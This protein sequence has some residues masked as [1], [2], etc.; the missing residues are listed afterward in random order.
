MATY[1]NMRR[2]QARQQIMLTPRAGS[3]SINEETLSNSC[4]GTIYEGSWS[5]LSPTSNKKPLL[6]A[7]AKVSGQVL[8]TYT[9]FWLLGSSALKSRLSMARPSSGSAHRFLKT[10]A[11][12]T[13]HSLRFLPDECRNGCSHGCSL[14]PTE[15]KRRCWAT[16]WR[17]EP[18]ARAAWTCEALIFKISTTT[19]S[20]A[21]SMCEGWSSATR[22]SDSLTR[23]SLP[24]C[25]AT[26]LCMS[27]LVTAVLGC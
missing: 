23:V 14:R 10:S 13:M 2:A 15:P 18:G 1:R 27:S 6:F 12:S 20:G 25:L 5:G 17:G 4:T 11:P 26:Y 19:P 16:S 24:R 8:R 7:E 3:W 9:N 21:P 22:T